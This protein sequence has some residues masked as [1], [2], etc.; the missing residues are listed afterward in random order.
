MMA[1]G[2]DGFE[3][4]EDP[5]TLGAFNDITSK[6]DWE[7]ISKKGRVIFTRQDEIEGWV[8]VVLKTRY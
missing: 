8:K 3:L 4:I 1:D 6:I 5:P 7:G 2:D